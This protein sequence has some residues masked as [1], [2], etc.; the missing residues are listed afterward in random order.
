MAWSAAGGSTAALRPA[1]LVAAPAGERPPV[2]R[3]LPAPMLL[4]GAGTVSYSDQLSPLVELA[5]ALGLAVERKW[6]GPLLSPSSRAGS[7]GG[8]APSSGA[9][10]AMRHRARYAARCSA[11]FLLRPSPCLRGGGE[12]LG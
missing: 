11:S 2:P 8:F 4:P 10:S 7:G 5:G 3:K 12:G 9:L 6:E 1:V